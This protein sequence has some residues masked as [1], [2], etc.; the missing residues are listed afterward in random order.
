MSPYLRALAHAGK[1]ILLFAGDMDSVCTH[2]HAQQLAHLLGL[3]L[4]NDRRAWRLEGRV[5]TTAGFWTAYEGGWGGPDSVHAISRCRPGP[6]VGGGRRSLRR[7]LLREAA[8][9]PAAV[10]QLHQAHEQLQPARAPRIKSKAS[11]A[12]RSGRERESLSL[13]P[14]LRGHSRAAFGRG[15]V[16]KSSERPRRGNEPKEASLPGRFGSGTAADQWFMV[17]G[18]VRQHVTARNSYHTA[19]CNSFKNL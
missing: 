9:G 3:K 18:G 13:P 6:A 1:R 19:L 17:F 8:R 11:R 16:A 12:R 14:P 10:R 4:L 5:P 15:L 2:A 7:L